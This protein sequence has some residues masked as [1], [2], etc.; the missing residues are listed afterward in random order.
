MA[1][2]LPDPVNSK[3]DVGKPKSAIRMT[4]EEEFDLVQAQQEKAQSEEQV[5]VVKRTSGRGLSQT[6]PS[7]K[8]Y[9]EAMN[10]LDGL[11]RPSPA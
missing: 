4:L 7:G 10:E 8:R 6:G 3:D 9:E 2:V 5:N 11:Y 1:S